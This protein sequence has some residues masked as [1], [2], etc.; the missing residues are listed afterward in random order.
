[1]NQ[2]N[3]RNARAPQRLFF[4][5]V[6]D[7]FG[8][9]ANYSWV[10]RHAIHARTQRGAVNRFS[11]MSGM[12][13][14]GVGCERFDS[15]SGATCFFIDAY[16]AQMHG[17]L[18]FDTDER[19][20]EEREENAYSVVVGNVGEVYAGSSLADSGSAYNEWCGHAKSTQGRASG[21][22]VTY[23]KN[24]EIVL[25]QAARVDEEE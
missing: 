22:E 13:W 24:G 1:M 16:D 8:G 3:A 5:E 17:G 2:A 20:E 23:F 12:H 10:T 18:R 14:H 7:T 9:E 6:T 4:V 25:S 11:R 15:A 19:T 21:E